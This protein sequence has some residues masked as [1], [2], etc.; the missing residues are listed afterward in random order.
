[1][2]KSK[3]LEV[4]STAMVETDDGS[5]FQ[6]T[7]FSNGGIMIKP[8]AL[9]PE[10]QRRLSEIDNKYGEEY[11]KIRE[12]RLAQEREAISKMWDFL[13]NF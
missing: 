9:S 12:T 1:M 5:T 6:R 11:E 7:V 8:V 3:K 2:G 13:I 10:R 4:L